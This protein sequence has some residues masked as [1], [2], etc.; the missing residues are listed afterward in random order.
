MQDNIFV[1]VGTLFRSMFTFIKERVNKNKK[2][3]TTLFAGEKTFSCIKKNIGRNRS[4]NFASKSIWT[5]L[6]HVYL[7]FVAFY[8]HTNH[9]LSLV[10]V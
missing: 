6:L 10:Y 8:V 1:N 4:R 9:K 3:T 2:T 5:L 7:F